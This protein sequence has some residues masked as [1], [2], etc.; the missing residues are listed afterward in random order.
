MAGI[1]KIAIKLTF[2]KIAI[3]PN[4]DKQWSRR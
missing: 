3:R 1:E 2:L 4:R